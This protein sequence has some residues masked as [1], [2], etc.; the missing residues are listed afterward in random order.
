MSLYVPTNMDGDALIKRG[1]SI[2]FPPTL[3]S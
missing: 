2:I 3:N 1:G